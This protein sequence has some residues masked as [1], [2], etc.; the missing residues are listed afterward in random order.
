MK[1]CKIWNTWKPHK[2]WT[3]GDIQKMFRCFRNG[4]EIIFLDAATEHLTAVTHASTNH[5]QWCLTLVINSYSISIS[6]LLNQWLLD[7]YIL[8]KSSC[9][10]FK[11]TP[12]AK[13]SEIKMTR[14]NPEKCW[15]KGNIGFEKIII[16]W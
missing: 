7:I 16:F 14:L 2:K 12:T 9:R 15:H 1:I 13:I 6:E 4:L 10:K 8:Q 5:T 11:K 3:L